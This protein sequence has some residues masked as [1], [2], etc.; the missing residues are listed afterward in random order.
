MIVIFYYTGNGSFGFGWEDSKATIRIRWW[1]RPLWAPLRSSGPG[2]DTSARPICQIQR[3]DKSKFAQINC[4]KWT[5]ISSLLLTE[6]F[7]FTLQLDF[8]TSDDAKTTHSSTLYA[9]ACRHFHQAATIL[10]AL[11]TQSNDD[12]VTIFPHLLPPSSNK[13]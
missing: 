5:N 6:Y 13:S 11:S 4:T 10:T 12:N 2:V 1:T 7:L 3:N 8:D 9:T